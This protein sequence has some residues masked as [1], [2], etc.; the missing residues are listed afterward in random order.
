M[1]LKLKFPIKLQRQKKDASSSSSLHLALNVSEVIGLYIASDYP[2]RR[3]VSLVEEVEDQEEKIEP[4]Y[5]ES[6]YEILIVIMVK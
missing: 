1:H 5:Y 4:I 2:N 6:E 3:F